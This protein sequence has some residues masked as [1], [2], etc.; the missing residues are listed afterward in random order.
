[1]ASQNIAFRGSSD[2]LY[3]ENNRNFL[4]MVELLAE[5][6][7]IMEYG[8]SCLQSR[9]KSK[10]N[11]LL[12][13]KYPR[14]N[15]H[16]LEQKIVASLNENKLPLKDM[17]GQAY[18]N[19]AN[20][21]GKN[22]GLQKKILNRNQRALFVSCTAHSLNLVVVDSVKVGLEIMIFFGIIQSLYNF[23]SGST[24][25]WSILESK[26]PSLTVKSLSDTRWESHIRA[27]KAIK[28]NVQ[29]IYEALHE[30]AKRDCN[31]TTKL[32]AE[33]IAAKMDT[34]EHICGI[35]DFRTTISPFH[36]E[37]DISSEELMKND[38]S[39]KE[40][41]TELCLLSRKTDKKNPLDVLIF[42]FTRDL[43][44][45]FPNTRIALRI[46]QTVPVTVCQSERSF[47][48]LKLIKN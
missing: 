17:R 11:S 7:P 24:K 34:L 21:R 32:S 19:G 28:K 27:V 42:I 6:E 2:K 20:M 3:E 12:K 16:G 9:G 1:M 5:F 15:C 38:I 10:Q 43:K 46:L 25:S 31:G 37:N 39:S 23:F 13:Q 41:M 36:E 47:S 40:L 29:K 8:I 14:R 26:C 48:K 35:E 44:E 45:I 30:V 22:K 18:D 33:S 4:K